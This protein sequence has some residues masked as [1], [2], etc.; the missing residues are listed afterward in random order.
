M[1]FSRSHYRFEG[2]E[3]SCL[4][5]NLYFDEINNAYFIL[6]VYIVDLFASE[7]NGMSRKKLLGIA[8]KI[9]I[10]P[11]RDRLFVYS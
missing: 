8:D 2:F 6:R 7:M 1:T 4:S 3:S 9:L 5:A 10:L 11:S